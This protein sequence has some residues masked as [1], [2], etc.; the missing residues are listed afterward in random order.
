MRARGRSALR[1]LFAAAL[2]GATF[3]VGLAAAPVCAGEG[4]RAAL[5]VDTGSSEHSLCVALPD[6]DVSGLDLI[7]LA[8]Q[9]HGLDYRFGFGGEAVCM[10][11]GVGAE[12]DD[13]FERYPDFWG[14]WRGDGSG[15]W[16]WSG[17]GAGSTRVEDGDVEGW[18]WGSGSDGSTHPAPPT[19]TFG[20]V[21]AAQS[22]PSEPRDDG[23]AES[24]DGGRPRPSRG[25]TARAQSPAAAPAAVGP[26]RRKPSVDAVRSADRARDKGARRDR[27]ARADA[28]VRRMDALEPDPVGSGPD[29]V[30]P[31]VA[32]GVDAREADGPPAAGVAAVAATGL[33]ALAGVVLGRRRRR[34]STP[35]G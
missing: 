5:V 29:E 31:A 30:L 1:G 35:D 19:T 14:Y 34:G 21:C 24:D 13:C 23:A 32:R 22:P 28:R 7:V 3:P 26:A 10:L 15:G 9:Q 17:T 25:T 12:G 27:S 6:D 20:S 18:A 16:Q 2:I 33:V 8:H 4:A 11:A